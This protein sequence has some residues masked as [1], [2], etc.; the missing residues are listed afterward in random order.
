MMKW[1]RM[2]QMFQFTLFQ[3]SYQECGFAD[4]YDAVNEIKRNPVMCAELARAFKLQI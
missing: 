3:K 1:L 2:L 4:L